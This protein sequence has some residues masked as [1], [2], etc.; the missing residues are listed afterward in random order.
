MVGKK[1]REQEAEAQA[2]A[3][4]EEAVYATEVDDTSFDS[5]EQVEAGIEPD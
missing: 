2:H 5:D 4:A 1:H 3:E